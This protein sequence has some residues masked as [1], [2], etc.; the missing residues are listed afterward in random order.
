MQLQ[1]ER[2]VA[3]EKIY[4]GMGEQSDWREPAARALRTAYRL[5]L[6]QPGGR[7]SR[8]A[9]QVSPELWLWDQQQNEAIALNLARA[10]RRRKPAMSGVA[11]R[12]VA[13]AAIT[14]SAALLDLA[15]VAPRHANAIV[16]EAV[17]MREA[18][19]SRYLD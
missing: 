18:Y 7:S 14:A 4:Q 11:A 8:R 19:L 12:R 15:S 13:L 17:L 9:L 16:E 5:R 10:I 2:A 1:S 6:A 3:I